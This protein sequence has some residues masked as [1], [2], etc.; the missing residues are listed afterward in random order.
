MLFIL[1]S[2]PYSYQVPHFVSFFAF[3]VPYRLLS[4][5]QA[6]CV[7]MFLLCGYVTNNRGRCPTK[8]RSCTCVG[9]VIRGSMSSGSWNDACDCYNSTHGHELD[10]Q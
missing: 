8:S 3:L 7:C 2:D 9:I 1:E 6:T 4:T 5:E 10:N